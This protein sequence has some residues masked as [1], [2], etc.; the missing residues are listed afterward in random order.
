MPIKYYPAI[1][2]RSSNE[3]GMSF[4]DFPGCIA[5]GATISDACVSAEFALAFH[6]DAMVKDKEL[7]PEPSDIWMLQDTAGGADLAY[8]MVRVH[9]AATISRVLVSMDDNLL[10]AI[11]AITLDRSAFL[12]DAAR[13]ALVSERP[14]VQPI[15]VA[16]KEKL[17]K[18]RS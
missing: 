1:I 6:I 8:V 4:P 9:I 3:F 15:G 7:I 5:S 16:R 2:D 13:A 12:A 17:L 10:R 14:P 11:D 18:G